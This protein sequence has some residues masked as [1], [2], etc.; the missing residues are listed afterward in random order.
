[1]LVME[2]EGN[3]HEHAFVRESCAFRTPH[4]SEGIEIVRAILG[5]Y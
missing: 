3:C 5:G 4:I 1:V 2:D